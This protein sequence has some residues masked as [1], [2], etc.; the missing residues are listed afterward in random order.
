MSNLYI[1][2]EPLLAYLENM[3]VSKY[4]IDTINNE[5]RF[6]V[7]HLDEIADGVEDKMLRMCGCL[8]CIDR[9]VS[10]IKND[11]P[12]IESKCNE[13]WKYSEC[14]EKWKNM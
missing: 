14:L 3:G 4:I 2:K 9:V 13:C 6:S 5:D 7:L 1:E 10:M 8:N 12:S 11:T